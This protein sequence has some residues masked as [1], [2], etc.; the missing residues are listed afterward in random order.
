MLKRER[1]G[2]VMNMVTEQNYISVTDLAK[3]LQISEMT[4]HRDFCKF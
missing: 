4:I 3:S 1:L 2:Q